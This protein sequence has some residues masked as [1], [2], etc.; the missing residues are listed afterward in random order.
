MVWLTATYAMLIPWM[1]Y[2]HATVG[3]PLLTSTN[4]GHTLFISLGQLPGNPWGITPMDGDPA[5]HETLRRHFGREQSSLILESDQFL[6]RRFVE[7][8]R[9]A[10]FAYAKKCAYS[11]ISV[12]VEGF[13]PGV[14]DPGYRERIRAVYP[15]QST[16]WILLHAPRIY[17]AELHPVTLLA[18]VSE[19]QARFLL[20]ASLVSVAVLGKR[21]IEEQN[22][23]VLLA[24]L[25][26]GY[27]V[28]LNVATFY[29]RLYANTQFI[30]LMILLAVALDRW[31]TVREESAHG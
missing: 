31:K 9:A 26:I 21:L 4:G 11:A 24:L 3:C 29:M 30:P 22:C 10:P 2:T 19:F 15:W 28:F 25:A 18:M 23:L 17:L 14:F 6:R 27:Q 12:V 20:L 1:V 16:T 7:L 8:I 5:M 13:Y